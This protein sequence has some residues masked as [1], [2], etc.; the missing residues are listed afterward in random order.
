MHNKFLHFQWLHNMKW[1]NVKAKL[2]QRH[3]SAE[4]GG[5]LKYSSKPFATTVLEVRGGGGG[6]HHYLK[7]NF[8]GTLLI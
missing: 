7:N 5:R 6:Q 1:H 8:E 4:K 3:V 2:A